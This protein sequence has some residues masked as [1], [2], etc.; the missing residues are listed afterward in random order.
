MREKANGWM[1]EMAK[2]RRV[3]ARGDIIAISEKEGEV[4]IKR[5]VEVRGVSKPNEF[6]TN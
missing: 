6:Y 1:S 4:K 2:C 3:R 5:R